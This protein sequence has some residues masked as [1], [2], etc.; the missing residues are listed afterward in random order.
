MF[1]SNVK[2]CKAKTNKQKRSTQRD[3]ML[4]IEYV[5]KRRAWDT[6]KNQIMAYIISA[7]LHMSSYNIEGQI[8]VTGN[9]VFISLTPAAR[10]LVTSFLS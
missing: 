7:T 6:C 1:T 9:F 5:E 2:T 4:L 3:L 10:R 8:C